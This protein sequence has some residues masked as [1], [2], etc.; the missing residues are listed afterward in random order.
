MLALTLMTSS[1]R[2]RFHYVYRADISYDICGKSSEVL[3]IDTCFYLKT[4]GS[5]MEPMISNSNSYI[6]IKWYDN[7]GDSQSNMSHDG[8]VICNGLIKLKNIDTKIV[9]VGR[10]KEPCDDGYSTACENKLYTKP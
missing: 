10:D 9:F 2:E 3:H 7:S 4:H 6:A 1:C 8:P 5:R